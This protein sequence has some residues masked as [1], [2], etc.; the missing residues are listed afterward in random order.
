MVIRKISKCIIVF[1]FPFLHSCVRSMNERN[2]SEEVLL[3][4]ARS[5]DLEAYSELKIMYL[6]YES[7]RIIPIAKYMVDSNNHV[8]ANL[9]IVDVYFE[10]NYTS[11]DDTLDTSS[12]TD[13]ERK[14]F[15]KYYNNALRGNL[16]HPAMFNIK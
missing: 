10:K 16:I 15:M 5:G 12:L 11:A 9:D 8:K 2:E 13:I 6:D 1:L 4:K 3:I 14:E 7:G